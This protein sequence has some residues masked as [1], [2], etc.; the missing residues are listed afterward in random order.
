MS[1]VNDFCNILIGDVC[2]QGGWPAEVVGSGDLSWHR[3]VTMA[4]AYRGHRDLGHSANFAPYVFPPIVKCSTSTPHIKR[5][6]VIRN[7]ELSSI[8]KQTGFRDNGV[9]LDVYTSQN[10]DPWLLFRNVVIGE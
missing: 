7:K 9:V 5:M 2:Y 1:F 3:T 8:Y 10:E 6:E 4:R